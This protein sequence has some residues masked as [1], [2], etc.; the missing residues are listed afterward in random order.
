MRAILGSRLN[1]VGARP[2]RKLVRRA[3]SH[4]GATFHLNGVHKYQP[5]KFATI[6]A[7][8]HDEQPASE[9]LIAIPD[10][11]AE[12]NHYEIQIP[13]L[14][15]LRSRR[16]RPATAAVKPLLSVARD[17]F[18]LTEYLI[19]QVPQSESHRL[20]ALDQY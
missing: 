1:R 5:A 10:P 20:A 19:E 2:S 4:P 12:T 6:E 3:F 8:W 17:N 18:D 9:V 13:V 15:G 16:G 7:R 14:G 11:S